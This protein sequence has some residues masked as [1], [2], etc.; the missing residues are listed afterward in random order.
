MKKC[1]GKRG[2][3]L[4][5]TISEVLGDIP[6]R[7]HAEAMEDIRLWWRA[8]RAV[9]LWGPPG[10]GKSTLCRQAAAM[11]GIEQVCEIDTPQLQPYDYALAVPDHT[12]ERVKLYKSGFLPEVGPAVVIF[13]ELNRAKHYQQIPALQIILDNR[14]G[15][16]KLPKDCHYIASGNR[17]I[18]DPGV[19]PLGAA[20]LNR[21]AHIEIRADAEQW[22]NNFAATN[23]IHESIVSFNLAYPQYHL[24]KV[25]ETQRPFATPRSWHF[26][27]DA[28]SLIDPL[29]PNR[30]TRMGELAQQVVG[31]TAASAYAAYMKTLAIVDAEA[32]L[33]H[34]KLPRLE[35]LERSNLYGVTVSVALRAQSMGEKLVQH[36][37]NFYAFF[38]A[39][40]G[41]FKTTFLFFYVQYG[42]GSRGQKYLIYRKIKEMLTPEQKQKMDRAIDVG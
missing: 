33:H 11:A 20:L 22:A 9:F 17:D 16:L 19:V 6:T 26:L 23:G 36:A 35:D 38:D 5:S 39:L 37:Q 21:F 12:V 42:T 15:P 27:S 7:S 18:D 41:D 30:F 31:P 3:R 10:I 14:I 24:E 28:V 34:G 2:D 32:V 29:D 25:P 4:M 13:E 40:P 1:K 8:G